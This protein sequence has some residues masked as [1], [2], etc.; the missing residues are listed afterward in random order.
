MYVQYSTVQYLLT[1]PTYTVQYL[2]T[3]LSVNHPVYPSVAQK[4]PTK[5]QHGRNLP[6]KEDPASKAT[7]YDNAQYCSVQYVHVQSSS[8]VCRVRIAPSHSRMNI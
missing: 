4:A 6:G 2:L 5:G 8:T 3:V 7:R 1:V